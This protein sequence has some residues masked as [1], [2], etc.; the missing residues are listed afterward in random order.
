MHGCALCRCG[1]PRAASERS[2]IVEVGVRGHL[3]ELGGRTVLE[4]RELCKVRALED[5]LPQHLLVLAD[6][7]LS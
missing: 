4:L 1:L 5:L 6:Y 3:A 2:R 7:L